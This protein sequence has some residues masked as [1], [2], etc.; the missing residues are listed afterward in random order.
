MPKRSFLQEMNR[1]LS[2]DLPVGVIKTKEWINGMPA[3]E[4][5]VVYVCRV[6]KVKKL[7]FMDNETLESF[8][9]ICPAC[10]LKS[11]ADSVQN[12]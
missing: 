8:D 6:C 7:A 10:Q 2:R 9:K 12:Q 5:R 11:Q 1:L 4:N 3:P